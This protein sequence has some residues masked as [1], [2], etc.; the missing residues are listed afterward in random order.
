MRVG[1]S[2]SLYVGTYAYARV[3]A[4]H[5]VVEHTPNVNMW[6]AHRDRARVVTQRDLHPVAVNIFQKLVIKQPITGSRK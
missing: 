4:F 3:C 2:V 5:S 6:T 1:V